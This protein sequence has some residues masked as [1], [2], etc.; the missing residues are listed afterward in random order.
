MTLNIVVLPWN[1][2]DTCS[3][4]NLVHTCNQTKVYKPFHPSPNPP[5]PRYPTATPPDGYPLPLRS[6][7]STKFDKHQENILQLL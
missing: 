2:L 6:L 3:L 7:F 5:Q 1:I 4:Q